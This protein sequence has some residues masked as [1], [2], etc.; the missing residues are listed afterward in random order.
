[1]ASFHFDETNGVAWDTY[2]GGRV[3]VLS[4]KLIGEMRKLLAGSTSAAAADALLWHIGK[5]YGLALLQRTVE[6]KKKPLDSIALLAASAQKSGWGKISVGNKVDVDQTFEI[7]FENCAFCEG[8]TGEK[9]PSCYFLAGILTGIAEGLFGEGY[10]ARET[11]CRSVQG[12]VC[13][14]SV[15]KF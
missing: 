5:R 10:S 1:M 9:S 14:F 4:A 15:A 3:L 13:R 7:V 11:E 12:N 8:I 2:F 6:M